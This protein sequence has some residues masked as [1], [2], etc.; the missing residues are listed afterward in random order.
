MIGSIARY[1]NQTIK[2]KPPNVKISLHVCPS[3]QY[4]SL[5]SSK[6]VGKFVKV[7]ETKLLIVS[8]VII[9]S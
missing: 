8:V 5:K 9:F 7:S 4:F 2:A 3:G 6:D 1:M